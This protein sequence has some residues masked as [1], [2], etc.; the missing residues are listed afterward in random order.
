MDFDTFKE[1]LAAHDPPTYLGLALEALWHVAKGDWDTAHERAQKQEDRDG[2]WVHAH[3]HRQEGDPVNAA[4]W[5]RRAG[6]P[7]ASGP[8]EEEWEMIVRALLGCEA[9]S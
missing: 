8:L 4:Y 6:K 1:S 7:V 5:Y 9:V 2:S 3:L